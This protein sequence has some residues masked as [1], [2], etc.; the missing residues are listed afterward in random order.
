MTNRAV[1]PLMALA[2]F[3]FSAVVNDAAASNI[4]LPL[5]V[6][7]DRDFDGT[8]T[9]ETAEF[10]IVFSE[11]FNGG[12]RDLYDLSADPGRS[13]NLATA[14]NGGT[15][16]QGALFDWDFYL[17][18][19]PANAYEFMTTMGSNASAGA[20]VLEILENSAARVQIQQSGHPRLNNGQGPPGDPFPEL[21]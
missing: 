7:D 19:T 15:Y 3:A 5:T 20:A 6:H 9:V 4:P 21:E 14:S 18:S 1:I 16:G 11:F 10:A 13:D 8:I 17:G 2:L 12:I